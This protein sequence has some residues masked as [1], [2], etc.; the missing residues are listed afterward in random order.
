MRVLIT[1]AAGF[2]GFH[3][4]KRLLAD[5]HQVL[6]YDGM[7]KYYDVTLKEAR[8]A[9]LKRSNSFSFVEAL[10]EDKPDLEEAG[11]RFSPDV[12][13]HL[14]A[15]AG[16]R[17]SL[18]APDAYVSANVI[19][20]FNILELAKELSPKHLLIASTSSVY[21]GNEHMPFQE[22]DRTDF[23]VSLY[24]ATKKAC[25]A[26]SHSY[27]HLFKIPTTCFR[28]FT[29]YGPW[30]R[31]D[32][33]LFKFVSAI[34]EGRPIEI[35][36]MGQMKR[37]FTYID[38][39]I[40]GIVQLL[41]VVPVVGQPVV[42]EGGIDSLSPAAPW[43]TV[44][45][46][47]GAPTGLM[48]FIETIEKILGREASKTMLPMQMGDVEE[49]FADASLLEALTGFRPQISVESGVKAFI[50]WYRDYSA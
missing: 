8:L 49:T 3:L 35:Y 37:D 20:T 26:M 1:G 28:F 38:D 44:N 11:R 39:L 42:Y 14:A 36:G 6:G 18:E 33:A 9:I 4:S 5:G 32:M 27:S 46:A 19:G 7:T 24:A 13:V 41:D 40:S 25:E 17:Y 48:P 47:G 16:V 31:P 30:G 15:Q 22:R 43:R 34:E 10:L 2:I 45:I 50:D 21:G 29:V 23:P 12:V